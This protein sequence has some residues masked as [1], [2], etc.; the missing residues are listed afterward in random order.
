[1]SSNEYL[2]LK[3]LLSQQMAMLQL[4]M[5]KKASVSFLSESTGKSRQAIRQL[6]IHNYEPEKDFWNDGGK[7]YVSQEVATAILARSMKSER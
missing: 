4:L 7:I 2:E 3:G 1:M 5:P 6:L